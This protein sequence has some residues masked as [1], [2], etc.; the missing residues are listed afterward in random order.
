MIF[1]GII[2]AV[3]FIILGVLVAYEGGCMEATLV[4]N[5]ENPSDETGVSYK[6]KKEGCVFMWERMGVALSV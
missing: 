1:I 4:V 6:G 2:V 5:K 3:D